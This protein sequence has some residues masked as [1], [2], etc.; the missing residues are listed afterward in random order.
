M[1][2]SA[3]T[4]PWVSPPVLFLSVLAIDATSFIIESALLKLLRDGRLFL[5]CLADFLGMG[6]CHFIEGWC[7]YLMDLDSNAEV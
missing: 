1:A 4:Y 6:G 5:Y 2:L 7:V 3:A